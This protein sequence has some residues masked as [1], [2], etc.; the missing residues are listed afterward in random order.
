M[1]FQAINKQV[2]FKSSHPD[3]PHRE[4]AITGHPDW[5]RRIADALNATD[6]WP[7]G[8]ATQEGK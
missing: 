1:R 4:V 6:K 7:V 5:A 2:L 3:G 8:Q